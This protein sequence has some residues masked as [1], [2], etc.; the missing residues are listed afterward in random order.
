MNPLRFFLMLFVIFFT[1]FVL[2]NYARL[3]VH[4]LYIDYNWVL[5]LML[6]LGQLAFQY[7]FIAHKT[8]EEQMEYF[9]NLLMVSG[10]GALMLLPLLFV[11]HYITPVNDWINVLYF[12]GVV[13]MML[14]EHMRRVKKLTMPAY[15]SIT[16]VLYRTLI[17]IWLVVV[18]RNV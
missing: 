4:L 18:Q 9:Y 14:F 15:L 11:N 13:G 17:L 8:G 7:P 1:A 2:G 6:V 3:I 12:F 5:E 16:W 10:L